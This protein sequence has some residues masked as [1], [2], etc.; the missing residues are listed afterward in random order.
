MTRLA[1]ATRRCMVREE[2]RPDTCHDQYG[3]TPPGSSAGRP[4]HSCPG[5]RNR[6]RPDMRYYYSP[7]HNNRGG[8]GRSRNYNYLG[9][10]S[11][12]D[13]HAHPAATC[14]LAPRMGRY[15]QWSV[16]VRRHNRPHRTCRSRLRLAYLSSIY[17]NEAPK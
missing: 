10:Y 7:L 2:R 13:N 6:S 14:H 11:C 3:C 16:S 17:P 1:G 15:D 4:V 12:S 5:R 8:T 9:Y